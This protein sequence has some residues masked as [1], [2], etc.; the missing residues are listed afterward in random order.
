MV[1]RFG[2]HRNGGLAALPKGFGFDGERFP[3]DLLALDALALL[4]QEG[5]NESITP[6]KVEQR[7]FTETLPQYAALAEFRSEMPGRFG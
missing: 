2:A 4:D 3:P 6:M 5:V 7:Q 1:G